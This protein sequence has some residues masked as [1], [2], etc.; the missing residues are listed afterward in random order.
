[1]VVSMN[2]CDV[3]LANNVC[4]QKTQTFFNVHLALLKSI[5]RTQNAIKKKKVQKQGS[6]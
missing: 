5:T 3:N 2:F 4:K 6:D 1:M